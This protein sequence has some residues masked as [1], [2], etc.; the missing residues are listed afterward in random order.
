MNLIE[1]EEQFNITGV[2]YGVEK[3]GEQRTNF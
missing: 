3:E 2:R 1:S